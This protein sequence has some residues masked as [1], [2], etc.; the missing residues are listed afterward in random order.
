L[1]SIAAT[2]A[3]KRC[4]FIAAMEE[5]EWFSNKEAAEIVGVSERTMRGWARSIFIAADSGNDSSRSLVRVASS[6]KGK[7]RIEWSTQ[8]IE[9]AASDSGIAAFIAAKTAQP[10]PK[11]ETQTDTNTNSDPIAEI[12]SGKAEAIAANEAQQ[13]ERVGYELGVHY[14]PDGTVIQAFTME[15]YLML[16]DQLIEFGQLK[17]NVGKLE[18]RY[19]EH[20]QT[21][22]SQVNYLRNRLEAQE[23]IATRLLEAMKERN[24]IE[25]TEKMKDRE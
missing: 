19:E 8:G 21:Y 6:I 25:A 4:R 13:V 20:I 24:F 3:A 14:E 5:Q 11:A 17:A 22:E 16:R 1:V 7:T 15:E 12:H 2:I 23:S 10:T 18:R 9:I